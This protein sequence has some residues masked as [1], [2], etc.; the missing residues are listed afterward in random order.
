M[1]DDARPLSYPEMIAARA[2]HSS[3]ATKIAGW[4]VARV[5]EDGVV[6]MVVLERH[7]DV[8]VLSPSYTDPEIAALIASME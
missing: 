4:N 7:G 5:T 1:T 6:T 8:H 2:T 3:D